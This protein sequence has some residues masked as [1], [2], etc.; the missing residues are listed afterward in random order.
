MGGLTVPATRGCEDG[1]GRRKVLQQY[2]GSCPFVVLVKLGL[3][4]HFWMCHDVGVRAPPGT[5]RVRGPFWTFLTG[6]SIEFTL[7]GSMNA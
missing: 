3:V 4:E 6:I 1:I 5:Q 7:E 2:H